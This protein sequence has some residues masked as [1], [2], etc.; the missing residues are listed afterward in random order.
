MSRLLIYLSF[1]SLPGAAELG[2]LPLTG[3]YVV[4]VLASPVIEAAVRPGSFLRSGETIPFASILYVLSIPL[5]LALNFLMA[6][7]NE[8]DPTIWM[9]RSIHLA[10]V[11]FFYASFKLARLDPETVFRDI[12]IVGF[13]EVL[14]VYAAFLLY[15]DSALLR[16][17]TDF[18]GVIV[19][20]VFLL[21]AALFCLK[22][23]QAEKSG[24][25]LFGY[26]LILLATVL[27]GTRVLTISAALL[28]LALERKTRTIVI[29]G[30]IA[31]L[32]IPLVE[33]GLFGRFDFGLDDNL[34][35][36]T[37]KLEELMT[38]WGFF[39]DHPALGTGF[40]KAYQ[41]SLAV[42]EYTYS[43]NIVLFY[44]GYAG[45]AGV[46]IGLYPLIRLFLVPG[47]RVIVIAIAV[48]Y[49]SSTT[50]T[51]VKHSILLAFVLLLLDSKRR[52]SA[53]RSEIPRPLLAAS[54]V[55]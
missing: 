42:N 5:L 33:L 46:L 36:I 44:L 15:F 11:P 1:V 29:G 22:K 37:S 10:L 27:T 16:R 20:S 12:S 9:S 52:V 48:F 43:H 3:L 28:I 2:L 32:L 45:L 6:R 7:L 40:G 50:F 14:L 4:L 30:L 31:I 39:S 19:Y 25:Y 49:A 17:A 26:F 53:R 41:V 24:V 21:L 54:H 18:E 47:Y 55:P 34:I 8:V 38:L 51:N 35:T 13:I 23:Y